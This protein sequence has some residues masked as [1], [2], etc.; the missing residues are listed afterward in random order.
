MSKHVLNNLMPKIL[1][2]SNSKNINEAIMEW[3]LVLHDNSSTCKHGTWITGYFYA[4]ENSKCI[5]NISITYVYQ[6][7]NSINGNLI[8]K[9]HPKDYK[10]GNDRDDIKGIGSTCIKSFRNDLWEEIEDN[11]I[12][13]QLLHL[14]IIKKCIR[15]GLPHKKHININ[16]DHNNNIC[17]KCIPN[18]NEWKTKKRVKSKDILC[19]L[20]KHINKTWKWVYDNDKNYFNYLRISLK[21]KDAIKLGKIFDRL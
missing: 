8:P 15:C 10:H 9:Y 11:N 7:K 16:W 2:L 17:S 21:N 19:N 18:E 4:L 1:A 20:P 3:E 6:I 5:C 13:Y 14:D 12:K